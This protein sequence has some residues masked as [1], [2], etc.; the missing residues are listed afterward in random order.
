MLDLSSSP[1]KSRY[2]AK[3][4]A[5]AMRAT[6]FIGRGSRS[7]STNAYAIACGDLANCGAYEPEDI[8]F[9]S[10]E[11]ARSNRRDPD[12]CEIARA[13]QSRCSFITD[14]PSN[15]A[16][17]YN[18][19]ERQVAAFLISRGYRETALGFWQTT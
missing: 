8:V 18:V 17:T 13:C 19:G 3:D 1:R 15:R 2:F 5:K 6:K 7:S 12:F 4:Q 16:R 9:I 11:G 10:A 14:D